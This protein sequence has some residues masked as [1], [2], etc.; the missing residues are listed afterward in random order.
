MKYVEGIDF[1]VHFLMINTHEP[2]KRKGSKLRVYYYYYH[3]YF[4]LWGGELMSILPIQT[5]QISNVGGKG[6]RLGNIW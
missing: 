4:I 1:K 2:H 5:S 3:Y 6:E